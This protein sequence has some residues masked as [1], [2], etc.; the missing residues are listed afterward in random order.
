VL[1][2]GAVVVLLYQDV[3]GIFDKERD[4]LPFA[5]AIRPNTTIESQNRRR[6]RYDHSRPHTYR[7]RAASCPLKAMLHSS[8][9]TRRDTQNR[10]GSFFYYTHLRL[11]LCGC[12]WVVQVHDGAA[13][14][15]RLDR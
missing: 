3:R 11:M 6:E 12:A 7:T 5:L 1:R 13:P 14:A 8:Q 9:D 10:S 15:E 2:C 4:A